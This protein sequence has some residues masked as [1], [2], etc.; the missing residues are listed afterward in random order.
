[1]R[2]NAVPVRTRGHED[3]ALSLRE[4]GMGEPADGAVEKILLLIELHDVMA[5]DGVRHH[6]IPALVLLRVKLAVHGTASF[7][8][9]IV[10]RH[11]RDS[12][13]QYRD[14]TASSNQ[15]QVGI[16][17]GFSSARGK[18]APRFLYSAKKL[19]CYRALHAA[20]GSRR[21]S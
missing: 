17:A 11:F 2:A 13:I 5:W 12:P 3:D 9:G 14:P 6:S 16:M 19:N 1:A 20:F 8:A 10:E 21:Y 4:T 7:L 15:T 18:G